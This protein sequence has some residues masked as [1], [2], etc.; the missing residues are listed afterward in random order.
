MKIV[1]L[2]AIFLCTVV[3][4]NLS[5]Q[6]LR[7]PLP[8]VQD[9][10][11]HPASVFFDKGPGFQIGFTQQASLGA[12]NS[13]EK[14]FEASF[15]FKQVATGSVRKA[16]TR[17]KVA[18]PGFSLALAHYDNGGIFQGFAGQATFGLRYK[19]G[20][21]TNDF[22][23][24]AAAATVR[25]EVA[26]IYS[27]SEFY[28]VDGNDPVFLSANNLPNIYS[29]GRLS[30]MINNRV[31][32]WTYLQVLSTFDADLN[33]KGVGTKRVFNGQVKFLWP[34]NAQ[35]ES[36]SVLNEWQPSSYSSIGAGVSYHSDYGM[37]MLPQF[38][39]SL[40]LRDNSI[41]RGLINWS[42]F[43]IG[44]MI[45]LKLNDTKIWD[46][47]QLSLKYDFSKHDRREKM[48]TEK[49]E[50]ALSYY[51]PFGPLHLAT[52]TTGLYFSRNSERLLQDCL[53]QM[54]EIDGVCKNATDVNS[55]NECL[56][57]IQESRQKYPCFEELEFD[58]KLQG[59]ESL[60]KSAVNVNNPITV[61][62]VRINDLDWAS[63][64]LKM[65]IG[66]FASNISDWTELC[67][68]G[69]PAFCYVNFD[70]KMKDE[71][72]VYN[73]YVVQEFKSLTN[74][75][76]Y[77]ISTLEDWQSMLNSIDESNII[78]WN[79]SQFKWYVL[80]LISPG[81]NHPVGCDKVKY[82]GFNYQNSS[83]L[84]EASNGFVSANSSGAFWLFDQ[85]SRIRSVKFHAS[86]FACGNFD[87]E[88]IKADGYFI[89]L[90]KDN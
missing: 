85:N 16:K 86:H 25:Q 3:D 46:G 4:T 28:V 21:N 59:Y 8:F 62:T 83:Y 43:R 27:R 68:K 10:S 26:R 9:Y 73:K 72:F 11:I 37:F 30:T 39:F 74:F 15:N 63:S 54:R 53:I 76:G 84:S 80:C 36:S 13:A 45:S 41:K 50:A 64:N 19:V 5:A 56:T 55:C 48:R 89:R 35:Q 90:V 7:A 33:E 34:Q 88:K 51:Q 17:T 2:I 71:G 87:S 66:E 23:S 78:G 57:I 58:R 61:E 79:M 60:M 38:D 14:P 31:G 44:M 32:K 24:F 6:F 47:L 69:K 77:H 40:G 29:L 20:K 82:N 49:N 70:S 81:Y 52:N 42:C 1:I 65:E 67:S 22:I 18:F 12:E 75:R